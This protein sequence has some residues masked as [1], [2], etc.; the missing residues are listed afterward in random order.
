MSIYGD[1][2]VS[3]PE[4]GKPVATGPVG[5]GGFIPTL[6]LDPKNVELIAGYDDPETRAFLAPV[7]TAF[8]AAHLG[9]QDIDKAKRQAKRDPSRTEA[10]VLLQVATFAE[11]HQAKMTSKFDAV[12]RVLESQI[13][14]RE[15]ML[16]APLTSAANSNVVAAEVRAHV[17]A[18]TAQERSRFLDERHMS[19]DASTLQMILGGPGF[20]CGMT[21]QERA[22]RTR[23]YHEQQ[24]PKVSAQL[25]AM[26][27]ARDLVLNRGP[28]VFSE[29][30]R[31]IGADWRKIKRLREA[32]SAAD[33]AFIVREH[34]VDMLS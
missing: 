3:V 22:L 21:D 32:R 16:T 11:T 14:A 26:N 12:L 7:V 17:K 23:M 28:L 19:C 33:Q 6:A 8:S 30:T 15:A 20:L 18:M 4:Y 34:T 1:K 27:T 5:D 9:L 13:K 31:A 25:N 2:P 29:V 24:N 10:N